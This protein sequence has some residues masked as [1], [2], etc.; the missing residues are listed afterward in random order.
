MS[1]YFKK[2]GFYSSFIDEKEIIA[3]GTKEN[4]WKMITRAIM[5]PLSLENKILQHNLSL[6]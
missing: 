3:R 5:N 1:D 4:N 2:V 6:K